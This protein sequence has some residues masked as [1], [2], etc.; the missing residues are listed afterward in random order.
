MN[1]IEKLLILL[2]RS[3]VLLRV[4][5]SKFLR[6]RQLDPIAIV[7][8]DLI[9]VPKLLFALSLANADLF[10]GDELP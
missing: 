1:G 3:Q 4:L 6:F 10:I 2:Q 5:L 9:G 7:G 8:H